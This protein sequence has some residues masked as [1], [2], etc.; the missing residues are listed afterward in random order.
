[1]ARVLIPTYPRDVH[2]IEVAL[3]LEDRG[4]EAVLWCGSDF[5]TWQSGSIEIRA[6]R[7]DW[8]IAGPE[9]EGGRRG[10]FDVVWLRRPT[11]PVLPADL[12]PADL[13]VA[14]RECHDFVNALHHLAAPDAFWLNPLA[15]RSRSELK[16]VQLREAVRAG[17]TVPP[18][19]M[20]N[21]PE[22]IRRFLDEFHGRAVYKPFQPAQWEGDEEV[23]LLLTNEVTAADLPEDEILR[24][25]PGI[26]QARVEKAHE[27]RVTVMGGHVVTARLRSQ[28]LEATR[29]DWRAAG[30]QLRVEP[31][32]LPPA[33]EEACRRLMRALG[34]YFGAFDFIVTP[35]GEHVFLEV[36]PAGQFLWV[37]EANPELRLLAPFVDFLLSH[38][39]EFRWSATDGIRHADYYPRARER[40]LATGPSHV[41]PDSVFVSREEAE[42]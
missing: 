27:L 15:S 14:R 10:P 40:A 29:L 13:P 19:L 3:A 18:T 26:F 31:D 24:A 4:H 16:P 32:R 37:E 42:G 9:L 36:N 23:A 34:I 20:S 28:E 22:R 17:L 7:F 39:P 5:P 41:D 30:A 33:V 6:D 1:M 25:T 2:A 12:H 38:D 21:D 35:E 11:P 8:E